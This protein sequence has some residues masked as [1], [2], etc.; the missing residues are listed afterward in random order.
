LLDLVLAL[1]LAESGKKDEA[2]TLFRASCKTMDGSLFKGE[3]RQHMPPGHA[4]AIATALRREV[5]G[6]LK[7]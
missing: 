2:R 1:A 4:W 5:E 7:Q 6:L 3:T